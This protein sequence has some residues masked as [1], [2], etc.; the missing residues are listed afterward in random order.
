MRGRTRDELVR[1]TEE[2]RQR[3]GNSSISPD[4]V[5]H[6]MLRERKRGNWPRLTPEDHT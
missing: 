6:H 5:M 4:D 2:L 3:T 1:L